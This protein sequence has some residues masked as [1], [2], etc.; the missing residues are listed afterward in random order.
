MRAV[1]HLGH[2]SAALGRFAS[3]WST[4]VDFVASGTAMTN[5]NAA[6]MTQSGNRAGASNG[7]PTVIATCAYSP[8]LYGVPTFHSPDSSN[9]SSVVMH[10]H[11][12]VISKAGF[13]SAHRLSWCVLE[14]ALDGTEYICTVAP[15][16]CGAALCCHDTAAS[17]PR[18]SGC[19]PPGKLPLCTA[20]WRGRAWADTCRS[21]SLRRDVGLPLTIDAVR[22]TCRTCLPGSQAWHRRSQ[23]ICGLAPNMHC[24]RKTAMVPSE[25]VACCQ[26]FCCQSPLLRGFPAA[27]C[28]HE[29]GHRCQSSDEAVSPFLIVAKLAAKPG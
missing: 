29:A 17:S 2:P 18:P 16:K 28:V 24:C 14:S 5:W 26:S 13:P 10:L 4:R 21:A 9:F 25:V 27:M 11:P 12:L 22:V 8:S 3:S 6:V 20:T 23:V 7:C 19:D 15:K 1:R